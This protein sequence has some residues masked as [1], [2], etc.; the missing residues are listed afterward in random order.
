MER[1]KLTHRWLIIAG[2]NNYG[3]FYKLNSLKL[4]HDKKRDCFFYSNS[5]V[6]C[7]LD[8]TDQVQKLHQFLEV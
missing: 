4:F 1:I 2:F 6:T 8:Y 7:R 3:N 5:G